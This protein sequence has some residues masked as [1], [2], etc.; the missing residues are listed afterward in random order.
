METIDPSS[1]AEEAGLR[2]GRLPVKIAG[3]EFL[4]GGDIITSA[5]GQPLDRLE[6]FK[7]FVSSLKVGEKVRFTIYRAGKTDEIEL[8]VKERT[9]L[10]WDLPAPDH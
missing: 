1:P 9:I 7:L 8:R 2:G 6:N 3:E 5:N 4:L 10:P